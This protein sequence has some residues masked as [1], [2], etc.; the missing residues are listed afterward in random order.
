MFFFFLTWHMFIGEIEPAFF[1]IVTSPQPGS[2][3]GNFFYLVQPFPL[4]PMWFVLFCLGNL[5]LVWKLQIRSAPSSWGFFLSNVRL[6]KIACSSSSTCL[7]MSFFIVK[8]QCLL[9]S[10]VNQALAIMAKNHVIKP[11]GNLSCCVQRNY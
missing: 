3:L 2:I 5:H 9:G 1:P 8:P 11:L 6:K 10:W 7:V 4:C